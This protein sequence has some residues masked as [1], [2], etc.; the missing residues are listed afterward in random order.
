MGLMETIVKGLRLDRQPQKP[1]TTLPRNPK[2]EN[3]FQYITLVFGLNYQRI[4]MYQEYEYMHEDSLISSALELYTEEATQPSY[5]TGERFWINTENEFLKSEF[6]Q[7]KRRLDLDAIYTDVVY[8]FC[9][10]GDLFIRLYW[11]STSEGLQ[12]IDYRIHP[13]DVEKA[14]LGNFV[15]GYRYDNKLYAP[16]DFY[17]I[18]LLFN[19]PRRREFYNFLT[20][21]I[22]GYDFK[23][24]TDYGTSVIENARKVYKILMLIENS[25]LISRITKSP[26]QQVIGVQFKDNSTPQ[27][28]M[29]FLKELKEAVSDDI[30]IDMMSKQFDATNRELKLA[31]RIFIPMF[32]EKGT[33][34]VTSI[35]GEADIKDIVDL[36]YFRNKMF[37]ALRIP[38]A[39]LGVE[40]SLPSSLG[41]SALARLEIRYAKNVKRIQKTGLQF[42]YD[43]F[44]YH[45]AYIGKKDMI[46]QF[47]IEGT[48]ISSKEDQERREVLDT[49]V[50][51]SSRILD[52]LT[53]LEL[54]KT[55]D[56]KISAMTALNQMFL[57]IPFYNK[58]L[59]DLKASLKADGGAEGGEGAEGEEAPPE[60][61]KESAVYRARSSTA[62]LEMRQALRTA[63]RC[64]LVEMYHPV[65]KLQLTGDTMEECFKK[66]ILRG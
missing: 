66:D 22:D 28:A 7:F 29:D 34:N 6:D 14:S 61:P 35:G 1:G 19:K 53:S 38:K 60:A 49:A 44:C 20:V 10:Y 43:L 63:C 62:M 32:G 17:H 33:L 45:L 13:G 11:G 58:F 9:M 25:V 37:G 54:V 18:R 48:P 3:A 16:K 42:L 24:R 46:D 41:E 56:Q 64:G 27:E 57:K 4:N 40:E 5:E 15:L 55:N 26:L 12:Y 39:F 23:V 8:N 36:E 50:D 59:M 52:N 65:S 31:Q 30:T 21:T 51:L 47:S 2:M